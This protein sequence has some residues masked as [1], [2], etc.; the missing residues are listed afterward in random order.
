MALSTI[1]I[2]T[3][4]FTLSANKTDHSTRRSWPP[5]RGL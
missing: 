5:V 2:P 3:P 4:H 1:I